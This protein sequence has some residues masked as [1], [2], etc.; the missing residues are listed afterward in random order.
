[1]RQ[2]AQALRATNSMV[3]SPSRLPGAVAEKKAKKKEAA[4]SAGEVRVGRGRWRVRVR[5]ET[6]SV[7]V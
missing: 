7:G 4:E 2:V 3:R 1:M 6:L 5:E